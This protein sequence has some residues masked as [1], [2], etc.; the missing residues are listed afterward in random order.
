M[1]VGGTNN[2]TYLSQQCDSPALVLDESFFVNK[3][4]DLTLVDKVKH[5]ESLPNLKVICNN[6]G[7]QNVTIR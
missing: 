3:Y 6:E 2:Q 7:F 5:F 1:V 4:F